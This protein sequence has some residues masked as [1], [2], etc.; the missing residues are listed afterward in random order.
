VR[1]IIGAVDHD[2]VIG[3]S[4][5]IELLEQQTDMIVVLDHTIGVFRA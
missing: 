2:G 1:A 4:E 3:D 5:V